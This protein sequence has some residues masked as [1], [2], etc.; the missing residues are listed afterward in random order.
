M[1]CR[2]RSARDTVGGAD[3]G[4]VCGGTAYGTGAW[5]G[6]AGGDGTA[7][8]DVPVPAPPR[9]RGEG[10]AVSGCGAGRCGGSNRWISC[11]SAGAVKPEWS[12]SGTYGVGGAVIESLPASSVTGRPSSA[13]SCWRRVANA[14]ALG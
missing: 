9:G 6:A 7:G 1:A 11:S 5:S 4:T 2:D 12:V 13:C 14:T 8:A 3:G 10:P